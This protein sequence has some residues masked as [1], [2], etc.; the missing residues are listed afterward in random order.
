MNMNCERKSVCARKIID[1][2]FSHGCI[3]R[4]CRKAIRERIRNYENKHDI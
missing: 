4:K 2:M 1:K 3:R